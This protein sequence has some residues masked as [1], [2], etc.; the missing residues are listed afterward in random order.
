VDSEINMIIAGS[1]PAGM[2][3]RAGQPCGDANSPMKRPGLGAARGRGGK[4]AAIRAYG[5][6]A[7]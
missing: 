6:G 5:S 7:S 4:H 1:S 3:I 2:Q